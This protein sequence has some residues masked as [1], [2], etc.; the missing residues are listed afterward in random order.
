MRSRPKSTRRIARKSGVGCNALN[1]LQGIATSITNSVSVRYSKLQRT[2]SPSGD[3][4]LTLGRRPPGS[5]KRLQRTQS[6]S[7]D[8]NR[9]K[10][11]GTRRSFWPPIVA[12]HS[13]PFRGL[14]HELPDGR[15]VTRRQR[16]NALNPLQGIATIA[17]NEALKGLA[18]VILSQRTQSPSGD[19]NNSEPWR[20]SSSS[21]TISVAT[22]SI[23][24]RGLQRPDSREHPDDVV[25][26]VATHSIPFRGLQPDPE[27]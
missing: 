5:R 25:I 16:C 7:G 1:P 13:I 21:E 9:S 20:S 2:Q 19:C 8:C 10:K 18:E 4:N 15:P 17:L 11:L 12:T 27:N 22:H 14:Q 26:D 6:P 3:C 24:F 23:P